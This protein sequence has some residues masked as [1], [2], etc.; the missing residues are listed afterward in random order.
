[1]LRIEASSNGLDWFLY[2]KKN[3]M[4]DAR[5]AAAKCIIATNHTQIRIVE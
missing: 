2:A 3:N 1:M 5:Q 4:A